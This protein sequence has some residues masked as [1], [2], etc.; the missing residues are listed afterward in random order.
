MG[1]YKLGRALFG[2]YFIY[3]GINHFLHQKELAKFAR[4]KH[5][6]VPD[7]AVIA[8]GL[9]LVAGGAS[10]ALGIK[11]KLGSAS[12]ATFLVAVT[13]TIHNF[14]RDGNSREKQHNIVDFAK[15]VALLSGTV[16]LAGAEEDRIT[17]AS[18]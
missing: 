6:P 14:W 5:V 15:N 8:S 10:I 9:A 3:S 4:S 18:H 2:S 17:A 1:L 16:A 12:I 7:A 13:P 11:P